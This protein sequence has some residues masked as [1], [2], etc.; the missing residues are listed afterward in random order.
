MTKL[1]KSYE[2]RI[3]DWKSCYRS[4]RKLEYAKSNFDSNHL[5]HANQVL[6][7]TIAKRDTEILRLKTECDH[8]LM[9]VKL[10]AIQDNVLLKKEQEKILKVHD[11]EVHERA[12]LLVDQK[13]T[14]I[15]TEN[16]ILLNKLR[17]Y[18]K[19]MRNV[20][21]GKEDQQTSNKK[22]KVEHGLSGQTI[23]EYSRQGLVLGKEVTTIAL[24]ANSELVKRSDQKIL[25]FGG[26]A[27]R[28]DFKL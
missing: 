15:I 28:H 18:E 14:R 27:I 7:E 8:E 16:V 25:C 2:T 26:K 9:M 3:Q 13:S 4:L 11:A 1:Y 22:W 20:G 19:E 12:L 10:R 17:Q 6:Q 21:L 23:K 24:L 5:K